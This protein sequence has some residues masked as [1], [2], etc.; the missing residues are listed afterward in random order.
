MKVI[1]CATLY[2]YCLI[3]G[4]VM[5]IKVGPLWT[6]QQ[7][8]AATP[9]EWISGPQ[10]GWAS[11]GAAYHIRRTKIGD[12]CF[13][14]D[15]KTWT[16]KVIDNRDRVDE[17]FEKGAVA[18]ITDKKPVGLPPCYPVYY[19]E[20]TLTAME[21]LARARRAEF[22]G[23]TV[24]VN[25]SV[26]K[27]SI[28]RYLH[29][30]LGE[31]AS[32]YASNGNFNSIPGVPLSLVQTPKDFTYGV[33]ECS[34]GGRPD[35]T[36]RKAKLIAPHVCVISNITSVHLAYYKEGN[37]LDQVAQSKAKIFEASQPNGYAIL[38][39]DNDYFEMLK[40]LALKTNASNI[41]SFGEHE[42]SDVRLLSCQ[43]HEAYSEVKISVFGEQFDYFVGQPGK[44]VILNTLAVLASVYALGADWRAAATAC[45]NLPLLDRRM[46][47]FSVSLD[48]GSF[49]LIDDTFNANPMSMRAAFDY[50]NVVRSERKG[51]CIAVLGEI[52]E[53]GKD[54][55]KVH[56]E[57][58]Q[59]VAAAKFDRVYAVGD[60]M[61][62]V[63]DNIPES[64]RGLHA[65]SAKELKKA[66]KEVIQPD[67]IVLLKCGHYSDINKEKVVS[68]LKKL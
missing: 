30:V 45:C 14:T 6:P 47:K 8:S 24:C 26:G 42:E 28:V 25:G 57:L 39:R 53:L 66:L 7:I 68:Y 50:V 46:N 19:V 11:T 36:L 29:H 43:L 38:N 40:S 32:A 62:N 17:Y 16:K 60:L 23:K 3:K 51:R 9:G 52:K 59:H 41:I 15:P 20:N 55:A 48:D 35:I 56:T 18:V 13:T 54:G 67:D 2:G 65:A 5:A 31:Q 34:M 49:T 4:I 27:S 37:P 44:H 10:E 33:Y 64:M 61:S 58:A 21:D 22:E 12:L 1:S 63:F